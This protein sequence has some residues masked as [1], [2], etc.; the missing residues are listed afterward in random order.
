[1]KRK[2][3]AVTL[4][5]D[6]GVD[7]E[8]FSG[9]QRH[10]SSR[11]HLQQLLARR[12]LRSVSVED[13]ADNV[14]ISADGEDELRSYVEEEQAEREEEAE[15]DEE[16]AEDDEG[17]AE[18]DDEDDDEEE[19]NNSDL[20]DLLEAVG[21]VD[22][23]NGQ[24]FYPFPDEKFFL[25]YCYAHSI[26]RPKSRSD[27]EFL[28]MMLAR[29][30]VQLP[31]LS[32]VL[33][34]KLPGLEN[35]VALRKSY[36]KGHPFYWLPPSDIIKLQIATPSVANK[37]MRYP[38]HTDR[39]IKELYQGQKW[40]I[41]N[42]FHTTSATIHESTF[43]VKDTV[44]YEI[45][46][47]IS[48]G[49]I[50]GFFMKKSE[51]SLKCYC[52]VT[53]ANFIPNMYLAI[54][55]EL[56]EVPLENIRSLAPYH[57][58][59]KKING[60]NI[61]LTDEEI[62]EIESPHPSK[63]AADGNPTQTVPL[64]IFSDETSGNRS[65]KWNQL[66]T[67]SM[68]LAGLPRKEVT[69]F[70]N[71][72]FICASNLVDSI[73]L[74][75]EIATDLKALEQGMLM[76][77]ASNDC[78]VFVQC[79][80]L[81]VACD[82]PRASEFAHHMGSSAKHFCRICDAT[83]EIAAEVGT[84]RTSDD[85][86]RTIERISRAN[87][88]NE[89]TAM[90]K[91]TGTTERGGQLD[92]LSCYHSTQ[93]TMKSLPAAEK[94]K[95]KAKIEAFDFSAFSRRLPSSFVKNY[96]SCVGRDFKL[97]A[98]VSVFILDGIISDDQL[99]VWFY[100]SNAFAMAYGSEVDL[101]D[102]ENI[103]NLIRQMIDCLSE[104]HPELLRK[105]K[106]HMLLHLQDDMLNF[107]PP[108]GFCTERFESFNSIIRQLNIY[109]NRHAS[110]KDICEKFAKHHVLKFL[111]NGGFWGTNN[112]LT[113]GQGLVKVSQQ[114]VFQKF[115][116]SVDAK[117]SQSQK[118]IYQPGSLRLGVYENGRLKEVAT[119]D[120]VPQDMLQDLA[121][122]VSPKC[123]N[124]KGC[125]GKDGS[126]IQTGDTFVYEKGDNEAGIGKFCTAVQLLGENKVNLVL[127][128]PLDLVLTDDGNVLHGKFISPVLE[129]SDSKELVDAV[130]ILEKV[131]LAHYCDDDCTFV[132]GDHPVLEER[133]T[134]ASERLTYK[135]DFSNKR[136]LLN[137]F[138][139]GE[140]WKY[141]PD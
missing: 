99:Q 102:N 94:K 3:A 63:I 130:T 1:M 51:D 87:T 110:S 7:F 92:M 126:L 24:D 42:Q 67:Y 79:P 69:K 58:C 82:N 2:R 88:E 112:T 36:G 9:A 111:I 6:C 48:Y 16:E 139:L 19:V 33:A 133:E 47:T 105:Q 40:R 34:F 74:G 20:G 68:F 138:Y 119:S 5:I 103:T 129:E 132:N 84:L 131:S 59:F 91:E 64:V 29:F 78:Q 57:I 113:A 65:K 26:M 140:S 14:R 11:N 141:I 135:H 62:N 85:I 136:Y 89:K 31:S 55:N 13:D 95:I 37:L 21:G 77:D 86:E 45:R 122:D 81:I 118:E 10:F 8:S 137:K 71:I 109:S 23:D 80:V 17:E 104:V 53:K 124:F 76:Y 27:L 127:T 108:V 54:T 93:K 83:A 22:D 72:H 128:T 70:S 38:E 96:G 35:S 125:I 121:I 41:E 116:Y 90:R 44:V 123:K 25:L 56:E 61:Q 117:C 101:D 134:I 106:F 28:W 66:E 97:W 115:M 46:E 39:F 4:C 107:G 49:R 50:N 73:S 15:D 43:Y 60:Q 114:P 52:E 98:Q 32:S 75:K 30:G 12:N 18:D 100:L 120:I